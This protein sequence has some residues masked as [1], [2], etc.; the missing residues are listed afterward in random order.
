MHPVA[1]DISDTIIRLIHLEH[2]GRAWKLRTRAEIPVP[3][4][5]IEDGDIQR[6]AE[7][8]QLLKALVKAADIHT[9]DILLALP[10]RHTFVKLISLPADDKKDIP[11][12]I[13]KALPEHIPYTLE[14]VY[15]DWHKLDRLNSLGQPQILIGASPKTTVDTYVHVTE[16]AG[17]HMAD[18]EV[19]SIAIA[20]AT[21]GPQPPDDA[22]IILDLG[23]TRSTLILVDH[24]VVQFTNTL[25][26]AGRELN[27]YIADELHI[28][29]EQAE[30]AKAVFGLDQNRGQGLLRKVLAPHI[31]AI[32]VAVD[33]VEHF[34]E[35]H[36]VDHR[37]ITTIQL[38]GS[39]ALLRGIDAELRQRLDQDVIL[40]PSWMFQQLQQHEDL[41][42]ELGY[43]YSTVFG[44]ALRESFTE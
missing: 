39:G 30:R 24:G 32:A 44:L 17:L 6:P 2:A 4:G 35:E 38:S 21:L 10:E 34:F 37:P 33:D 43:T 19:E 22:R 27:R 42:Q 18:A 8:S 7:V 15:W 11:G 40:T 28:T 31:D 41:P 16:A 12:A 26:Y 13:S 29:L 1:V 36:F 23:R 9:K 5:L 20:R 14:E 25:R 3:A